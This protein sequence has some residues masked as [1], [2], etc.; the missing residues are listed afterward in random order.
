MLREDVRT[1]IQKKEGDMN[2]RLLGITG[3]KFKHLLMT[4]FL[5][6][7]FLILGVPKVEAQF[8]EAGIQKFETPVDAADFTL[9][10][11]SGKEISL[12]E[13]RGKVAVIN[14]FTVW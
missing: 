10:D 5:T 1:Q 14:F 13:L 7:T 8:K 4:T 6:V 11:L 3:A 9:K 12:R 2:T